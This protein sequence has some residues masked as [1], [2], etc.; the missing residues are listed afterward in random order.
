MINEPNE[1]PAVKGVVIYPDYTYRRVIFDSLDKYQD[2]VGGWIEIIRLNNA[3]AYVNEEGLIHGLPRNL[4]AS[5]FSILSD[6]SPV[7]VGNMI[8]VGTGNDEGDDTNISR[9]WLGMVQ[10]FCQPTKDGHEWDYLNYP[11]IKVDE[12]GKP[13]DVKVWR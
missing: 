7:I 13:R 4:P 8:I 12:A 10:E 11:E 9:D 5:A 6:R 2:A 1:H 3:V